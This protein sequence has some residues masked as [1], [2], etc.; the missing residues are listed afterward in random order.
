MLLPLHSVQVPREVQWQQHV[1]T[2][3]RRCSKTSLSFVPEDKL[4][5]WV[6][7]PFGLDR[8]FT[9]YNQEI[10]TSN[11]TSA[12]HF[13]KGGEIAKI[14]KTRK[15]QITGANK[16]TEAIQMLLVCQRQW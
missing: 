11:Q 7:L 14:V 9:P 1:V 6:G 5:A 16:Q 4:E 13:C 15:L 8:R 12:S 10:G 2:K 3:A